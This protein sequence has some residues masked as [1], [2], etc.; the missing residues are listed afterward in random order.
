M[1]STYILNYVISKNKLTLLIPFMTK[2]MNKHLW[3]TLQQNKHMYIYI[4]I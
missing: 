4:Y 1:Y 2:G 3:F